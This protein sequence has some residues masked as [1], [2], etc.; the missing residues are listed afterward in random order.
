M[1]RKQ[2]QRRT[3]LNHFPGH[4]LCLTGMGSLLQQTHSP[5]WSFQ[6]SHL[7]LSHRRLQPYHCQC[8]KWWGVLVPLTTVSACSSDRPPDSP[9]LL[10]S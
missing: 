2:E 7:C 8:V 6:V 4:G 5:Q 10:F 1:G 9:A 3:W